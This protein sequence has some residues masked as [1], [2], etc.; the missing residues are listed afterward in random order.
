MFDP[1]PP[2][3]RRQVEPLVAEPIAEVEPVVLELLG[4][5]LVHVEETFSEGCVAS[6][7]EHGLAPLGFGFPS[8]R[9][10]LQFGSLR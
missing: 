8:P 3:G 5:P 7:L 10:R 1:V 9:L 2:D 6:Q 4:P